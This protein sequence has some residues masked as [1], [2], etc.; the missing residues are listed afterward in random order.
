M[1]IKYF[2]WPLIFL[3]SLH[4][5]IKNWILKVYCKC[6]GI[7]LIYPHFFNWH[8]YNLNIP[9]NV[10]FVN[11]W[12]FWFQNCML[13]KFRP[14][15]MLYLRMLLQ[16]INNKIFF[17]LIQFNSY[18]VICKTQYTVCMILVNLHGHFMFFSCPFIGFLFNVR[19]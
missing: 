15:D 2:S 13:R 3:F 12:I 4:Q 14:L 18:I 1:N 5:I 11:R 19:K 9:I 17:N 8:F 7:W 6:I 10:L 16:F